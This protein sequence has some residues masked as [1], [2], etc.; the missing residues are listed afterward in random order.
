M[1]PILCCILGVCCPPLQRRQKLI[2]H[3][4]SLHIDAAGAERAADD[5]LARVDAL[6]S[7]G[8]GAMLKQVHAHGKHG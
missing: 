8:L 2:N 4:L 6:L 5:L 3:F 1:D 7:T